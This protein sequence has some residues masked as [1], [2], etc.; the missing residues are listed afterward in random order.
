MLIAPSRRALLTVGLTVALTMTAVPAHA[1]D[2]GSATRNLQAA[3]Q[4]QQAANSAVAGAQQDLAAAQRQLASLQA[5]VAALDATVAQDTQRAAQLDQQVATDKDH[6]SAYLRTVYKAG[7]SYGELAYVLAAANLGDALQRVAEMDRVDRAGRVLID[8]ITTAQSQA[9]QAVADATSARQQAEVARQ[10]AATAEAL[11]AVQEDQ[12]QAAAVAA[13][14]NLTTA[15][16]QYASALATAAAAAA[17]ARQKGNGAGGVVF[18]PVAGPQFTVDTNLTAPSGESAG[19]LDA[20]LSGT[21]LAGLGQSF[22]SAEHSRQV[23]ARYLVAHAILE[24]NWGTSAIATDKHNLFGYG[25]DDA[26]PYVDAVS[27]PSFDAC[28]QSVA[29][30]VSADYLSSSGRFYHGPTLRGMN[31]DYASDPRWAAKIARIANTI[32]D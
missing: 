25:A 31:I 28:I 16:K 11:V 21:A 12:T 5:R 19:R 22:M 4:R 26:N 6:L 7:G 32:P 8:Q 18:T 23:S 1:D 9:H 17:S 29:G 30:H 10:Q 20:F 27:F 14:Q 13:N 2:V 3:K 24:S 15:Q